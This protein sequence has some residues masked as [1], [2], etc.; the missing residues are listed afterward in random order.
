MWIFKII[1]IKCFYL[2]RIL[3]EHWCIYS[4][5]QIP[6][7]ENWF[8]Y[9]RRVYAAKINFPSIS[10]LVILIWFKLLSKILGNLGM[11]I[12]SLLIGGWGV[13]CFHDNNGLSGLQ[14]LFYIWTK[15]HFLN[16][17]SLSFWSYSTLYYLWIW[18]EPYVNFL[19]FIL[20][21]H[22]LTV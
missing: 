6:P 15:K 3:S 10:T 21:I 4:C 17:N 19:Y 2:P 11:L 12:L 18:T 9:V 16:W 5:L 14:L 7:R 20:K 8:Q 1:K 22:N 13:I